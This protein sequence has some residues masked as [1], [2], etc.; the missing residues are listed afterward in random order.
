MRFS[1]GFHGLIL[2]N[3]LVIAISR[4]VVLGLT[5]IR[6]PRVVRHRNLNATAIRRHIRRRRTRQLTRHLVSSVADS[7]FYHA[8]ALSK[9]SFAAARPTPAAA[10]SPVIA[11]LEVIALRP[12]RRYFPVRATTS[13]CP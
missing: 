10:L 11:P 7:M 4:G 3:N 6:T 12:V 5:T 1:T 8:V 13:L 2:V 9:V